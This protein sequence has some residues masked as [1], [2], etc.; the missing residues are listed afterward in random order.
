MELLNTRIS[1]QSTLIS[2]LRFRHLA[3]LVALDDL[4]NLHQAALAVNITQPSASK[5][6]ADI[7]EAFGF[8]LFERH[9]RGMEPSAL[10]AEALAYARQSLADLGRFAEGLEV[11]RRGGHGQLLVGAIMGAAPDILARAVADLKV[12]RPLLNVRI[13]GETSDQVL[14]L[15]HRREIE[16]AVGRFT[17]PL[18]HNEFDFSAL[19]NE[20]MLLVVRAG[21]PLTVQASVDLGQI[22]VWPWV[23]QPITSPARLLLEEEFQRA[24]L[25]SPTNIVE[26]ASIFATLQLLQNSEAIAMLPE[27]VV[28]DYLKASVLATLPIEIGKALT[29]FGLLVRK[30]KTLSEPAQRFAVLL[31]KYSHATTLPL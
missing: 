3:L 5:M 28:R 10:G 8:Q 26:C 22:T 31:R 17:N 15:L 11:K 23:I 27:S 30:G 1:N 25:S 20:A 12:E 9:A 19:A 4:R 16:L 21:H 14:D 24:Q 29:G 2:R 13:L 18:Q 7:E 6:L